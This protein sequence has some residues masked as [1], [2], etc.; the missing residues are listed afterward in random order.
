MGLVSD[1]MESVD[2][3]VGVSLL[4]NVVLGI[5]EELLSRVEKLILVIKSIVDSSAL[6]LSDD[7]SISV[8]SSVSREIVPHNDCSRGDSSNS[9]EELNCPVPIVVADRSLETCHGVVY[10]RD[11]EVGAI[12][13]EDSSS[14]WFVVGCVVEPSARED[15]VIVEEILSELEFCPCVD[16]LVTDDRS[17]LLVTSSEVDSSTSDDCVTI[18]E[19]DSSISDDCVTIDDVVSLKSSLLEDTLKAED[20]SSSVIVSSE[21][22]EDRES[23]VELVSVCQFWSSVDSLTQDSS[24]TLIVKA[25]VDS[26]ILDDGEMVTELTSLLESCPVVDSNDWDSRVKLAVL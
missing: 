2:E 24:S 6:E 1:D 16:A 7:S 17:S 8:E 4:E 19:V 5:R 23:V 11:E 13:V 20:N 25:E 10:P 22:L 18:D 3:A 26:S 12:G 9:E 14:P 15:R 21:V